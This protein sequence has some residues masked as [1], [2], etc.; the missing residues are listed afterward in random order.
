MTKARAVMHATRSRVASLKIPL[1]RDIMFYMPIEFGEPP[2]TNSSVQF[3]SSA[4]GGINSLKH[5]SSS[6]T[7]S[8]C[9]I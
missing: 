5:I 7:A 4:A 2:H 3:A 1:V 6:N 8:L 9:E